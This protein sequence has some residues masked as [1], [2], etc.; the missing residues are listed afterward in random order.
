MLGEMFDPHMS[1]PSAVPGMTSSGA[2][3][4]PSRFHTIDGLRGV[5]A[6]SVVAYHLI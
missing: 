3:K 5:A 4:L 6:L 2:G 1:S